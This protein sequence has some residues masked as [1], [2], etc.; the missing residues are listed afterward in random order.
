MI[1][2]KDSII[3]YNKVY[4]NIIIIIERF[5]ESENDGRLCASSL[6]NKTNK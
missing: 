5:I 1:S 6:N 4:N 3:S 2:C